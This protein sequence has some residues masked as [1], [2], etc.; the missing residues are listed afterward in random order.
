MEP[1]ATPDW[2]AAAAPSLAGLRVGDPGVGPRQ[3][4]PALLDGRRS[5]AGTLLASTRRRGAYAA[6]GAAVVDRPAHHHLEALDLAAC[7]QVLH[8][9]P[10]L[11][12]GVEVGAA[13]RAQALTRSR[14]LGAR[15]GDGGVDPALHQPVGDLAHH[16]PA[17][18]ADDDRAEHD[19][20]RHDARPQ[21]PPPE[22]QRA[23]GQAAQLGQRSGGCSAGGEAHPRCPPCSPRRV[24][25]PR[26]WG[27]PGRPRSSPAAAGR[28]R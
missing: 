10:Q 16:Q 23:G 19:D 3:A 25:S 7:D 4:V 21:R 18:R 20:G 9:Q 22:G 27:S 13:C 17:D 5:A 2:V 28:A 8:E 24:R 26:S 11:G 6:G 1:T 12:V 14:G 15:L